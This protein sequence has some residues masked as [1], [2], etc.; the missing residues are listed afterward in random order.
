MTTSTRLGRRFS[1]LFAVLLALMLTPLAGLR[2]QSTAATPGPV[3]PPTPAPN[4]QIKGGE[5]ARFDNQYLDNHPRVARELNRNPRLVDNPAYLKK[6]PQLAHYL[7]NHPA[8]RR[9]I[10]QHPYAFRNRERQY[11]HHEN[12]GPRATAKR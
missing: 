10:R 11:Q 1:L 12:R 4:Q 3:G 7:K 5:V 9:N 8:I 2:A 6:H